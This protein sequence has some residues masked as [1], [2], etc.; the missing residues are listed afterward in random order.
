MQGDFIPT[1]MQAFPSPHSM[2]SLHSC[3]A[4]ASEQLNQLIRLASKTV[5]AEGAFLLVNSDGALAVLHSLGPAGEEPLSLADIVLRCDLPTSKGRFT[6]VRMHVAADESFQAT[7]AIE[8]D[9]MFLGILGVYDR[10]ARSLNASEEYVLEAIAFE[11]AVDLQA[12]YAGVIGSGVN[13]TAGS[14]ETGSLETVDLITRLRLLESVVV[15]ANDSI[16]ITE[17][18]PIDDPGP[19]ILYANPAFLRTTGYTLEEVIGKNPRILQGPLSGTEAPRRIRAAMLA[20]EPIVI[21]L[22][23]YRKDGTTFWVEL[24]I[25]PVCDAKGWFTH[26]VSVQR[27]VTERK[28]LEVQLEASVLF[29]RVLLVEHDAGTCEYVTR[30]LGQGYR[31]EAV[32]TCEHAMKAI[33]ASLPDL[34]LCDASMP[35][36]DGFALLSALRANPRTQAL[37]IILLSTHEGEEAR[38]LAMET[39]ASDYLVK[40]FSPLQLKTRVRTQLELQALRREIAEK[41]ELIRTSEALRHAEKLA[42]VGRLASSIAHEINNPLE[43]MS[44]LLYLAE[45]SL[46]RTEAGDYVRQAQAELVR[47]ANITTQTLR[48]H[49]Q[50]TNARQTSIAEVLDGVMMLFNG[51]PDVAGVVIGRRYRG[52]R[53]I[54]AFE[55]DLRQVFANLIGNAMDAS[56]KGGGIMLRVREALDSTTG[57][58]GVRVI[59]ADDGHGMSSETRE[60]IFEAFFT[61]KGM[62]GTGLGLWVSSEILQNHKAKVRVRSSQN[63]LR[64]GTI[65]SIFFPLAGAS[66]R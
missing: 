55:A 62:T 49:R 25:S 41:Q 54:M 34:L 33:E 5:R 27:D 30:S 16:L 26:W 4:T 50:S 65:F 13:E 24:S 53:S 2:I 10:R 19:V 43:A 59:V 20:W 48:F 11:I 28:L 40:P 23:N 52:T 6:P 36:V 3:E 18:E 17:A 47:I 21:E 66:V 46:G 64:H 57:E 45:S 35:G 60:R 32:S 37:P 9:G 39:G 29:A 7:V 63:P 31:I 22:L 51:R 14:R 42:V 1:T 38:V 8:R 44:N 15:N 12:K 61:T 56:A 58:E